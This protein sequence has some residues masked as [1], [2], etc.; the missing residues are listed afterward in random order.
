MQLKLTTQEQQRLASKNTDSPEAFHAYLRGRYFWNKRTG[1]DL[2][3]A[4]NYFKQ[5]IDLDPTYALAYSSLADCYAVLS[6]FTNHPFEETFPKAKALAEKALELDSGLA[7]PH[8]T[9]AWALHSYYW[10]WTC[11]GREYKRALELNP[12]YGTAHQWYG[13]YLIWVGRN[14]E[15]VQELRRALELDPV[16][17]A[18]NLNVGDALVC[19][20]R[21]DEAIKQYRV[22]LEMDPNFIDTHL[23]LGGAYLQKREFEQAITE[24]E[25]ARQLS[26]DSAEALTELGAGYALAGEAA[27]T[28]SILA[29]LQV[30]PNVP[31]HYFAKLYV[32]LGEKEKA[33]AALETA[34]QARSTFMIS[35]KADPSWDPLHNEPRFQKLVTSIGLTP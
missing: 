12:D 28:M 26:H 3:R 14:E 13:W 10:D 19:A 2:E 21:P 25:R 16:S 34:C 4:I 29:R 8:V 30:M 31:P 24:F 27:K 11:A 18:I 7:E 9:L 17:L 15:G 6:Y 20:H 5:A 22:T 35:L 32:S 1:P 23:G 33:L